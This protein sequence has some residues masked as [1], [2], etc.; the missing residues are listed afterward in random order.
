MSFFK[1]LKQ[2]V[3]ELGEEEDQELTGASFESDG[4]MIVDTL[5]DD[6]PVA[7]DDS[8]ADIPAPETVAEEPAAEKPMAPAKPV[9][10]DNTP[11]AVKN[12]KPVNAEHDSDVPDDET[13]II[14]A[15]LKIHGDIE[16]SGSIE[17]LGTVEGNVTCKGKLVVSGTIVGNSVSSDFFADNARV[18][19]NIDCKGPVKIGNGSVIMGDL[20]ATGA[21]IAGAIKGNIDVHGP[22]ILDSTAIVMGDIKSKQVQINSGAAIE[23][24]CAQVYADNSPSKFFGVNK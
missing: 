17:L 16:S 24:M 10:A 22:V 9:K 3:N 5:T 18:T 2:A 15:G 20:N 21:V 12:E 6:E 4:D 14:T 11:K 1:D 13:A 8:P 7:L 19:G 23:G